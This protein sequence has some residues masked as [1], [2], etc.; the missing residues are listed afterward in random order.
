MKIFQEIKKTFRFS[1]L[2]LLLSLLLT[3][4]ACNLNN[5]NDNSSQLSDSSLAVSSIVS[6]SSQASAISTNNFTNGNI[7]Y[8]KTNNYNILIIVSNDIDPYKT[9][10]DH[11]TLIRTIYPQYASDMKSY[12]VQIKGALIP[13]TSSDCPNR[14]ANIL[15]SVSAEYTNEIKGISDGL[16][17]NDLTFEDLLE[18]NFIPDIMRPTSCSGFGVWG[19]YSTTGN[20]IVGRNLDWV[21]FGILK[22]Y[23]SLLVYRNSTKNKIALSGYLGFILNISGYNEKGLSISILDSSIGDTY[24]SLN[25][26]SYPFKI[27]AALENEYSIPGATTRL[28]NGNYAFSFNLFIAK[29]NWENCARR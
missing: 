19:S 28:T 22:K 4:S 25:K 12:L 24:S 5:G 26:D 6:S 18:L 8:L 1:G 11:G 27:R 13:N 15:K 21:D 7:V 10:K 29:I 17:T 16:G 2:L 3:T 14:V 20:P 23:N 9:G